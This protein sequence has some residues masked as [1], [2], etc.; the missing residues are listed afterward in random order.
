MGNGLSQVIRVL[1]GRHEM[2][3]FG[4]SMK[5]DSFSVNYSI[6]PPLPDEPMVYLWLEATDDLGN[7]YTNWG[8]VYGLSPDK[9]QTLG[10]ITGQPAVASDARVLNVRFSFMQSTKVTKYETSFPLH[11]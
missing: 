4:L 9:R 10:S 11:T 8:G 6:T 5:S 3:I 1:E 7:V 2:V